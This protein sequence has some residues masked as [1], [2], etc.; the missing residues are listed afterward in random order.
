MPII[1]LAQ[2]GDFSDMF[3]YWTLTGWG[4]DKSS[5]VEESGR[6]C[7]FLSPDVV[8]YQDISVNPGWYDMT[9]ELR[10]PYPGNGVIVRLQGLDA[11]GQQWQTLLE[12]SFGEAADWT[13]HA[14][15]LA[16]PFNRVRLAFDV[17]SHAQIGNVRFGP[18]S[19]SP[20]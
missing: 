13:P 11:A 5:V 4:A 18:S 8:M 20:S 10:A 3:S 2:N 7:A 14:A 6:F 15:K 19:D 9:F 1:D 16:I 17:F 12:Q